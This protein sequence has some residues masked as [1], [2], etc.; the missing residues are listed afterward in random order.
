MR[1]LL[2]VP[3][4]FAVAALGAEKYTGPRPE[5]ADVPYLMHA[6]KLIETEVSEAKDETRKDQQVA[7]IEG[8]TSPVKTPVAEPMFLLRTDKLQ[9]ERLQAYRL[10]PK[11]GRREVVVSTKSGKGGTKPIPLVITRL[12][13]NL[14]KLEVD[15]ILENG[16]YTLS[17]DGSQ[18]TFSFQVY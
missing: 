3:I 1:K 5:K 9:P 11:N 8:A 14:F 7:W 2:L 18:Q 12:D 16:E 6:D 17:P 10:E 13:Q 4:L 15:R